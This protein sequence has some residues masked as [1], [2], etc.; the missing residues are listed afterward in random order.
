MSEPLKPFKTASV[1]RIEATEPLSLPGA[2]R[3]L[4]TMARRL[5]V[6]FISNIQKAQ[7]D[8]LQHRP[9]GFLCSSRKH[10]D[11]GAGE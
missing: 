6:S 2:N 1:S 5:N 11:S 3:R 7:A 4:A 9:R 8:V 10:E